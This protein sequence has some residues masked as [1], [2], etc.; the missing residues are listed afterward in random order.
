MI[1][2]IW[3][4]IKGYEG[5][6]QVSNLGRVK[7]LAGSVMSIKGC[8]MPFPEKIKAPLKGNGRYYV[9]WLYKGNVGSR[10]RIHR[11]V[12]EAFVPNPE[13]K[14]EVDHIDTDTHNNVA[15][16]LRWVTRSENLM[17]P[18]TRRKRNIMIGD[19]FARDV[20]EDN[21]LSISLVRGRLRRGWSIEEAC[22]TQR[23]AVRHASRRY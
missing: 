10:I 2:E 14:P 18:T 21:G 22:T 20:A 1:K 9:V 16:N 13:G 17:N 5:L 23:R 8:L 19:R 12:A 3:K 11:L 4:D 15:T 6:Y 7:R